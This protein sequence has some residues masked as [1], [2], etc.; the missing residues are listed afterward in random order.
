M[1]NRIP[2]EI[3]KPIIKTYP[4]GAYIY[5]IGEPVRH[6]YF[7]VEGRV[8]IE[9]SSKTTGRRMTKSLLSSGALFGEMALFGETIRRNHAYTLEVAV[10]HSYTKEAILELLKFDSKFRRLLLYKLGNQ[11]V[12]LE[13][14]LTSLVFNDSRTRVIEFIVQFAQK[15]GK[16]VGYETLLRNFLPHQEVAYYTATSRQ[17]VTV[18]LNELKAKNLIHYHRK[19]L[20]IRDMEK[21]VKAINFYPTSEIQ[22]LS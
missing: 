14:R 3:I 20:L 22:K 9:R 8:K 16:R 21:L 1:E 2:K 15:E 11:V 17:T 4:K 6:I 19:R 5:K 18:V 10:I 7:V 13:Q 12:N